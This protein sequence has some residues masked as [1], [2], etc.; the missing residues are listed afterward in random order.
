MQPCVSA[1]FVS[2]SVSDGVLNVNSI[3][4]KYKVFLWI[5]IAIT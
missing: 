5:C 4:M 1:F 2:Q 3:T